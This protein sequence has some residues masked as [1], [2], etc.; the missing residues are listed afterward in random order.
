MANFKKYSV[1]ETAKIVRKYLKGKFPETKFSVKSNKYSQG[2]S[3]SISWTDGETEKEIE[4]VCDRFSSRL[5]SD[6]SDYSGTAKDVW[7]DQK[8]IWGSHSIHYTRS[9]SDDFKLHVEEFMDNQLDSWCKKLAPDYAEFPKT[10]RDFYLRKLLAAYSDNH[11][12]Y[13][14]DT[15]VNVYRE[16]TK[17]YHGDKQLNIQGLDL[18]EQVKVLKEIYLVYNPFLQKAELK[19]VW[20]YNG[21]S[22]HVSNFSE[23]KP[24][25]K[26]PNLYIV[27]DI[28]EEEQYTHDDNGQFELFPE[29]GKQLQLF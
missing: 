6:V 14:D 10:G 17:A 13:A 3:I 18:N 7:E 27:P 21:I 1:T 15:F 24:E 20:V 4:S 29:D 26:R 11:N 5:P 8:V 9:Y 23:K 25:I 12:F 28:K 22:Y 16:F 2:A 19:T